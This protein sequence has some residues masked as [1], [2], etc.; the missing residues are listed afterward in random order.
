MLLVDDSALVTQALSILVEASGHRVRTASS[1]ASAVA[2]AREEPPDALLVDLTLPD[3]DGL[4]IVAALIADGRRPRF[5]AA[6]T[7]HDDPATEARCREAG[8]DVVWVKPVKSAVLIGG[9]RN[10]L[11]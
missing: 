5:V 10:G 3:G 2:S 8:C 6:L 7:G 9:L 4:Q 11:A 1:V